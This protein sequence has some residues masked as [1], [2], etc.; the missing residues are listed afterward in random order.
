MPALTGTTLT[1]GWHQSRGLQVTLSTTTVSGATGTVQWFIFYKGRANDGW[2]Q[3]FAQLSGSILYCRTD[4]STK[5]CKI[6]VRAIDSVG[7]VFDSS[8]VEYDPRATGSAITVSRAVH[9]AENIQLGETGNYGK[10]VGFSMQNGLLSGLTNA[11]RD[12]FKPFGSGVT[13]TETVGTN[14]NQFANDAQSA[15]AEGRFTA[16]WGW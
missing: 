13:L 6:M 8:E 3:H 4:F 14:I 16:G 5:K 7:N 12:I 1:P 11:V 2:T 15:G 9:I 10:G